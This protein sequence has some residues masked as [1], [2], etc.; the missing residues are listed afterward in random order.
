MVTVAT[1]FTRNIKNYLNRHKMCLHA[2]SL[3]NNG[4]VRQGGVCTSFACFPVLS[5][6]K[7]W[8]LL[9]MQY[10]ILHNM[11][12]YHVSCLLNLGVFVSTPHF[13][14]NI[15]RLIRQYFSVNIFWWFQFVTE[16]CVEAYLKYALCVFATSTILG[17]IE[18]SAKWRRVLN[19]VY[20]WSN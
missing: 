15:L 7:Y 10:I 16:N 6:I 1:E 5:T 9:V 17:S 14:H 12:M 11:G 20:V 19:W 3:Y 4:N 2:Y 8:K 13:G 18:I